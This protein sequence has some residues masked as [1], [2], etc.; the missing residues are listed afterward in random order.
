MIKTNASMNIYLHRLQTHVTNV[1][2][3]SILVLA[4]VF[5]DV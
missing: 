4:A 1:A 2:F 3:E 5:T